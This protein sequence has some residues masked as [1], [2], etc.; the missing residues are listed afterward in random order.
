MMVYDFC[1][2]KPFSFNWTGKFEAPDSNWIHMTRELLDYELIFMTD[3]VLYI[4]ADDREYT[5]SK[6]EYVLLCPPC[7]QYGLRAS[8]CSFYW[9]H[10][11]Y[12]DNR[13]DHKVYCDGENCEPLPAGEKR[14]LLPDTASI[15]R[16]DRMLVLLKQLQDC[17]RTYQNRNQNSFL[18]TAALCELYSQLYLPGGISARQG[19]N[20]L[21]TDI[22]DY[23]SWRL[24]ENIKVSEIAANFGYNEKYITTFFKKICGISLKTYI[25]NRKMELAKAM[26]TDTNLSIAQIGYE[27]GF[28]DN[29]NFSS[30]FKKVTGQSPSSYRNTYS[31]H[32]TFHQ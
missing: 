17:D 25:Q 30:A 18:L 6:G 9:V 20:P 15:P 14:I 22:I 16:S 31:Q 13:N 24:R 4:G 8:A 11:S 21:Y 7:H 3:G 2:E 28:S 27:I 10:F 19:H 1:I 12:H 26:L 32:Q 5:V 23:I 29:H